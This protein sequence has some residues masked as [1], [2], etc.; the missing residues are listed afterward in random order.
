MVARA[1]MRVCL[2][3]VMSAIAG[4]QQ[5]VGGAPEPPPSP[6]PEEEVTWWPFILLSVILVLSITFETVKETIE[7]HT[8][9]VFEPITDAFFGELATLGFIGAIAFT[10]TYNFSGEGGRYPNFGLHS[11]VGPF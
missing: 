7:E 11:V 3:L 5:S 9:H 4:A 6:E 10:L 1:V 8:P 2:L